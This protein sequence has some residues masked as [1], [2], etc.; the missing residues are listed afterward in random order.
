M[1]IADALD[2]GWL[3][4]AGVGAGYGIAVGLVFLLVFVVPYLAVTAL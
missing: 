4:L 1:Y 2:D 3:A